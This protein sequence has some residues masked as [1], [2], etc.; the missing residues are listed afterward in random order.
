M[1]LKY[2]ITF[3]SEPKAKGWTDSKRES[4]SLKE[5]EML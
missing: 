5:I 4:L 1:M 3:D 2:Y